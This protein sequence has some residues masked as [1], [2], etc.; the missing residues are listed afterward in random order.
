LASGS[1]LVA[2]AAALFAFVAA[3]VLVLV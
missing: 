3:V 1:S 2:V